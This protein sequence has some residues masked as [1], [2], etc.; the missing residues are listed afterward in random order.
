[1]HFVSGLFP[2]SPNLPMYI[3]IMASRL[4]YWATGGVVG[5][6][7]MRNGKYTFLRVYSVKI[8]SIAGI[9]HIS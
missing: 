7:Y 1:M 9:K 6:L 8:L 2:S 5:N 4:M 3:R